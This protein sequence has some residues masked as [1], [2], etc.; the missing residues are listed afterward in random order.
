MKAIIVLSGPIAVGKTSFSDAFRKRYPA[1]KVSTRNYIMNVKGVGDDRAALQQAGAELDAE[2]NGRWVADVVEDALQRT[3]REY[4]L[5]DSVRIAGQ[6]DGLR[7]RFGS[8]RVHHFHLT[9]S[10]E[11]LEE[12]YRSRS[13]DTRE[14]ET[15]AEARAHSTEASVDELRAIAN[16]VV[17]TGSSDS[18]SCVTYATAGRLKTSSAYTGYVDIFVGGQWGSEGKGNI[19]ADRVPGDGVAE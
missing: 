2:T 17:D 8:D 14:F 12:R 1:D 9:A 10:Y 4:L 19:C 3:T 15:Y 6:V 7:E 13:R 18:S 16:V 5:V 11:V